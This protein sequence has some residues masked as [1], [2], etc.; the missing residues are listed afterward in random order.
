[1]F[2]HKVTSR[3]FRNQHSYRTSCSA[4]MTTMLKEGDIAPSFSALDQNDN[5][6]SSKDFI[7]KWL[8]LY[9]Y[10][11]DFTSG[12]T[13]EACKL[14]DN[15]DELKKLVEIVGVS[16]DSVESHSKFAEEHSLPF[17][18][19]S[20]SNRELIKAYGVGIGPIS[21]RVS[22]LIDPSSRIVKIYNKVDPEKH[23]DQIILD[24]KK[25][26]DNL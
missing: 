22:F 10:P 12:C 14:R 9:F 23:S 24:F 15:F 3:S 26:Y 20:D 18:L 21:K 17:T 16:A 1:M 19:L 8:L 6:V 5:S 25:V 2:L 4:I 7:D 11:K 13:T